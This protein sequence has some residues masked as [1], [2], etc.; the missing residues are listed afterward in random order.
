[1]PNPTIQIDQQ[2]N[3]GRSAPKTDAPVGLAG[4]CRLIC[5]VKK[6]PKLVQP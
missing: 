3:A 4:Q 5:S 2:P 1:M 6:H